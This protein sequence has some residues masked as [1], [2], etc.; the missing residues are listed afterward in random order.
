MRGL[1]ITGLQLVRDL[2][3]SFRR[4]E[5]PERA[6]QISYFLVFAVFPFLVAL[7]GMLAQF[8]LQEEVGI[9]VRLIEDTLPADISSFMVEEVH[10]IA[11]SDTGGRIVIGLAV[12][13]WSSGRAVQS[14]ISGVNAAWGTDEKRPLILI[15]LLGTGLTVAVMV[16]SVAALLV[17]SLGD[18]AIEFAGRE[19]NPWITTGQ[20]DTLYILR[21]VIVL[22]LVH[23]VIN[24]IYRVGAQTPLKRWAWSTYG[25]LMATGAWVAIT[26][27]YRAF[28][29]SIASL[30][31]AY[32]SLGAV[33]GLLIYFYALAVSVLL[34]AEIDALN[35][36]RR[37]DKSVLG[38]VV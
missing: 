9:M 22:F 16:F 11:F 31:V 26:L 1:L 15:R 7:L 17:L 6:A 4:H 35:W 18:T 5:I 13:L 33:G 8:D 23:G 20:A 36:N 32:G 14:V 27:G 34:G 12:A 25:S 30:G 21:W 28:V 38:V 29:E 37:K 2:I 19:P 24:V 10:N 3:L